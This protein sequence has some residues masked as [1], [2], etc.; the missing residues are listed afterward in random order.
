MSLMALLTVLAWSLTTRRRLRDGMSLV[1]PL[2]L[3]GPTESQLL[4]G[5]LRR[6]MAFATYGTHEP[7]ACPAMASGNFLG[8]W[9]DPG[10]ALVRAPMACSIARLDTGPM[11]QWRA[12]VLPIAIDSRPIQGE[13]SSTYAAC[14][15]SCSRGAGARLL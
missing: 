5:T 4:G 3:A 2:A 9:I 13:Q 7:V 12:W 14:T 6:L 15:D 8:Q 11:G 1:S 10:T